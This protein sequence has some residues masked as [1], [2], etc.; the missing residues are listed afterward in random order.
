MIKS[1]GE[2]IYPIEIEEVLTA[3]PAIADAAVIGVPDPR[4]QETVCAVMVRGGGA[5]IE[6]EDVV[7]HC[8]GQL[9]GYKKP[10]HARFV[11]ELP[12]TASG[13]VQKLILRERFEE[14]TL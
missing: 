13:K 11:E 4:Y 10:R 5:E 6:E 3:H 9:A 7:S 12:R 2:N 1:G 8:I 14:G